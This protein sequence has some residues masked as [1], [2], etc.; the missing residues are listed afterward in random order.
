[1]N[2]DYSNGLHGNS[3][4]P[5]DT[6]YLDFRDDGSEIEYSYYP[7]FLAEQIYQTPTGM[8]GEE[9]GII[10]IRPF[11]TVYE[12]PFLTSANELIFVRE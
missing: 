5:S 4:I 3:L 8:D 12:E 10:T 7:Y 6:N 9:E 2:D 1:M 11:E